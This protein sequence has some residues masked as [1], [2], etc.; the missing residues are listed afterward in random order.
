MWS[1]KYFQLRVA[2][3]RRSRVL[4]GIVPD[5]GSSF[6][7]LGHI[8]KNA[9][10]WV[11]AFCS[12]RKKD[13]GSG[14]WTRRSTEGLVPE[15]VVEAVDR[16]R[17][18]VACRRPEESTKRCG[19][20]G[21]VHITRQLRWT[22]LCGDRLIS[23]PSEATFAR[24][25]RRSWKRDVGGPAARRRAGI[26]NRTEKEVA[27]EGHRLEARRGS[28][29]KSLRSVAPRR[30]DSSRLCR[31]GGARCVLLIGGKQGESSEE[32][33][34]GVGGCPI[35]FGAGGG[36]KGYKEGEGRWEPYLPGRGRSV[37]RMAD[38]LGD[39]APLHY[40]AGD[41]SIFLRGACTS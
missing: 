7:L 34:E 32:G 27:G 17:P 10:A 11:L 1:C 33:E 12:T 36:R 2:A 18:Q 6:P 5:S 29:S 15:R 37:V 28:T 3:I 16:P 26:G 38:G 19:A 20:S 40:G 21:G 30:I 23:P 31:A 24:E 39:P 14:V 4:A 41:P 8:R 9:Q 22:Q 25:A 35:R 13:F